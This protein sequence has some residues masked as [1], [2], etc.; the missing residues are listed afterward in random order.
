MTPHKQLIRHNPPEAIGDCWRTCVACLLDKRPEEVP[1]F[2]ETCWDDAPE[3]DRRLR[4]YLA[5]QGLGMVQ[6]AFGG[7]LEDIQ[8][9][10]KQM[11]PGVHYMLGGTSR[12]GVGH[13][14]VCFEDAIV[15]DPSPT[16]NGIVGPM[17][18]GYFWLSFFV[19]AI[20]LKVAA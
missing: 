16:D 1:H 11:N 13:Q 10:M 17:S 14:V 2:V 8:P 20:L 6:L 5:T 7:K 3:A 19:P 4:A 18:D 15:W 9:W 12:I